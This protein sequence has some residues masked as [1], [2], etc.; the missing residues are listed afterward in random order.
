MVRQAQQ[1]FEI[2][3]ARSFVIGDKWTDIGLARSVGAQGILVRSGYGEIE[4]R[5][6]GTSVPP[7]AH[8]AAD[9]MEA[10]S[11]LLRASGHP[12]DAA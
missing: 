11:W 9:L 5:R 1:R 2:D 10:T 8:V 6:S 3:L 12:R 4:L 7:A